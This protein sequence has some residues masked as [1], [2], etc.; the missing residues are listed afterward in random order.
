MKKFFK[1]VAV[2]FALAVS[3]GVA[4]ADTTLTLS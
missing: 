2:G 3:Q 4:Q 1:T